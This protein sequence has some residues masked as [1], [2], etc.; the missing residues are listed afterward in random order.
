MTRTC[1]IV[2]FSL[3]LAMA[4]VRAVGQDNCEQQLNLATEEYNAGR[5]YGIPAML[6]DCIDGG[7]S[8]EQRLRAFLLLTQV[9]LLMD[10]PIGAEE[11]YLKVLRANPEFETNPDQDPIELVYLSKKFTAAPIFSIYG[12]VGGNATLVRVIH[13]VLPSDGDRNLKTSYSLKPGWLVSAGADWHYNERISLNLEVNYSFTSY[14]K[15]QSNRFEQDNLEFID[16]Q[17]WLSFPLA[18]RYSDNI[19]KFRPYGMAGFSVNLLLNDRGD[20]SIENRDA[21][22][23]ET[24]TSSEPAKSP[25]INFIDQRNRMNYSVFLGAGVRYKWKLDFLFAEVRYGFGLTNVVNGANIFSSQAMQQY[26][27][28]DDY[29]RLDNMSLSVGF[30]KPLYKPRKLKRSGGK[31]VL[32]NIK[33]DA[34]AGS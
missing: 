29:F 34:N 1:T 2:G 22:A 16:R 6:K 17:S 31:S 20:I 14:A 24:G 19:G 25:T 3:L 18:I 32:R 23:D 13:E 5:F 7:F 10:D 27:H 11:S 28:V 30:V 9:Y 26:G 21:K 8:K 4:S 15:N 33:K 12:K